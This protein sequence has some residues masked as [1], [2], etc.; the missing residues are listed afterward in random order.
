MRVLILEDD[1]DSADLLRISLSRILPGSARFE[2]AHSLTALD[3]VLEQSAEPFDWL[4][5]DM[6]LPDG[7]GAEGYQRVH[8][9]QGE[10][11]LLIS[12]ALDKDNLRPLIKDLPHAKLAGKPISLASLREALPNFASDRPSP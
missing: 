11:P 7:N 12:S 6:M 4:V 1:A 3:A 8:S 9:K 2:I 10:T 5:F